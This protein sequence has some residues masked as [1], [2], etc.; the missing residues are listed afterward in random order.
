MAHDFN[1]ILFTTD[2]SS[3][4]KEVF[5]YAVSLAIKSNASILILHVIE[6]E[7]SR[8]KDIVVDMIGDEAYEKI[9]QENESYARNILVGKQKQVPIIKDALE[10]LGQKAASEEGLE[11]DKPLVEGVTIRMG[12]IVDEILEVS[13]EASCDMIVMG[14]HQRSLLTKAVVGSTTRG[15]MRRAKMP[16]FLVPLDN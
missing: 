9:Q 16:V 12:K 2:L 11:G 10:K 6:D 14:H 8:T 7:S 15:V 5:D 13:V 1:R 3:R 4:S